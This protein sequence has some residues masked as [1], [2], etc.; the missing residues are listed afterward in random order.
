MTDKRRAALIGALVTV[1]VFLIQLVRDPLSSGQTEPLRP[2]GFETALGVLAFALV[3]TF[4]ALVS[5]WVMRR[6]KRSDR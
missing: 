5:L 4:A 3:F 1:A 6:T 2:T